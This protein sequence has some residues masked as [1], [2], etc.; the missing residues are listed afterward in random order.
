MIQRAISRISILRFALF[1]FC[2][3]TIA[4]STVPPIDDY[5]LA[6][7]ALEAARERDAA[8]YAP[9]Y[10]HRAEESYRK[11]EEKFRE[12]DYEKSEELFREAKIFAE[13]AENMARLQKYKSGEVAP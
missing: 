2:C 8:R 12:E 1:I 13:K 3:C 7:T 11:G 5:T 10:W 9:S 4:C 6:R